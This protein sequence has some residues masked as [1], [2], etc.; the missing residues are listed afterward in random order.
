[1]TGSRDPVKIAAHNAQRRERYA[2]RRAEGLCYR[3]GAILPERAPYAACLACRREDVERREQRRS[4][5]NG[6]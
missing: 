4:R 1:M 6:E 3:C 5:R 2:A